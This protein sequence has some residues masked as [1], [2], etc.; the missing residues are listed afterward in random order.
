MHYYYHLTK[1]TRAA[2]T[3][4][5]VIFCVNAN[6]Q[7]FQK[8][9]GGTAEEFIY[10]T[11][12]LSDGGYIMC[13]RTISGTMNG[14]WDAYVL[15]LNSAGDTLWTRNYGN[16]GYDEFQSVYPTSDGGFIL[17]GQTDVVNFA[18]DVYLVKITSTGA[19]SWS[20]AYGG[21]GTADFGYSVRQTS[22]GGYIIGGLSASAGAGGRDMLLI[23]TNSTGVVTWSKT[24]GGAADD[25]GRSVEPTADGGYI[26]AG[27]TSSYGSNIQAYVV[28]TTSTG[29]VSWS[30][31]FGGS[32]NELAYSVKQA[33]DQSYYV[34]GYTNS[35][36][37]GSNDAM[38][39]KLT[40]AGALSWSKT[41]G[42]T[43]D[44]YALSMKITSDNGCIL[45]GRT[46]SYGGGNADYYLIKT[47]AS[48]T[49]SWS[50]AYGG[51]A[52][53]QGNNVIQ[54]TDGG[55]VITG[56]ANSYGQGQKDAFII[57][58][59]AT[60]TSGCNEVTASTQT[61]SPTITNG[62]GAT[63]S[64]GIS[65]VTPTTA[66]RATTTVKGTQC[67]TAGNNCP[68]NA[69]F[70]SS[71]T[72]ICPGTT[73]TF[74][75]TTTGG[76]IGQGWYENNV[77]FSTSQSTQRTFNTAGTFTIQLISTNGT[78]Q[79]TATAII[80][81][82]AL[83]TATITP[84]G[85]TTFCTGGSVTLTASA[86]TSWLWA[87]GGQTTQSINVTSGGTY[88]VTVTANGCSATST[89]T[90]VTVNTLPTA[91]ITPGGPTTFC[92]G[93]SVTLSA[94]AGS[95]WL[96]APG[97][98]TTQS[99][100]VT[101]GGTY[102]VTVTNGNNCS[103]TSTGTTVTVNA[104]PTATI[105]PNGPTTFCQ[106]G[107]VVLTASAGTSWLWAPGGQTTQSINVIAG[108]TYTVTVT[109]GNN[110]SATSA[111]TTVTVNPLPTAT[112]TPSGSTTF[113][114]GGNVTL[115]ASAG[116]SW[117]WAPGGQTTQS[118]NVTSGGT[119]SVTVTNA[120]NCSATSAPTTVTVQSQPTATI[121]PSGA[122]TFC[123]G[124]SVT[125]T[126]NA[127]ASWL[128]SPGGQ[129][130]QSINVTTGG[131]YTVTV[132]NGPNCTA[133]STVTAVTVNPLPTAAILS[134]GPTTFCQGDSVQLQGSAGSSWLWSPGGETTQSIYATETGNYTVTVT[135]QFNCSAT[136][137]AVLVTANPTVTPSVTIS[138]QPQ[139]PICPGTC[140]TFTAQIN[141]GGS[142]PNFAWTINNTPAGQNSPTFTT[143]TLANNDVIS[144]DLTS[145]ATC[146]NPATVSSPT[147][148]FTV[149]PVPVAP[150]IT[151]NNTQLQSSSATG[152]QWFLVGNPN[153]LGSNQTYTPTQDGNYYI[154]CTDANGCT[155]TSDTVYFDVTGIA[156]HLQNSGIVIYPNPAN[157][158]IT[159]S[160]YKHAGTTYSLFDGLGR[161]VLSGN[162]TAEN[163]NINIG[164][165]APGM[166]ILSINGDMRQSY[167]VMK[168]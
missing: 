78:C 120:N 168:Q 99:I 128:W 134:T 160:N 86:G 55:Y 42:G 44:D 16:V 97:G 47:D 133:T 130:T 52:L 5:A 64:A 88:S 131:N 56:Y 74:T 17:C 144:V 111:P 103:A 150:T 117:L 35:Y 116:S 145:N 63:E 8:T 36:G 37:A 146:A 110:C 92:T 10:T 71:A 135:N 21:A 113:C 138:S 132:S 114:T 53:D 38:L 25:E 153:V 98:Q 45:G 137:A 9:Y 23:K 54:T 46:A 102:T 151:I 15:R 59:D 96:W 27:F 65:A 68:V 83:P 80:T 13:G 20:T 58:T 3:L 49:H 12:Q 115:T 41:Y 141:T 85:P 50:K 129:T 48:G 108:G 166:Y 126:A 67:F 156:E 163:T 76:A 105:T 43:G 112:I 119:Y 101:A 167:K 77:L 31:T 157:D 127:G 100:N 104:L 165:L 69:S 72:S 123:Q 75:N 106:N 66:T 30:K 22:D 81:V 40:S 94:S 158:I 57:K 1:L 121:T 11:E 122:T 6:A 136:S 19:L 149:Y 90:T 34:A 125:L 164:G 4:F 161:I 70:T 148:T 118:I 159:V 143:C 62:T 93:G 2:F 140:V 84:S 61:N 107:G 14:S 139:S 82:N 24:Y 147:I 79:D 142:S 39:L 95:S 162:F 33:S 91:T 18:G 32:N 155:A 154:L 73:V 28:K 29:V 26:L 124:G 89:G 109:N 87:P 60:G 7:T 51:T 152:N